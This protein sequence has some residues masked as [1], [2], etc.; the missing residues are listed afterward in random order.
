VCRSRPPPRPDSAPRPSH[1]YGSRSASSRCGRAERDSVRKSS[2]SHE[3]SSGSC[4]PWSRAHSVGCL[5]AEDVAGSLLAA[6]TR[7]PAA[8]R[9]PPPATRCSSGRAV[10]RGPPP[11]PG[12]RRCRSSSRNGHEQQ[13]VGDIPP[14]TQGV[15]EHAADRARPTRAG[16][17]WIRPEPRPSVLRA[18][19]RRSATSRPTSPTTH[20]SQRYPYLD[21]VRDVARH[22]HEDPAADGRRPRVD[23]VGA[24]RAA[25]RRA[26]GAS[27]RARARARVA[28][29]RRVG[30]ERLPSARRGSN[31]KM[32]A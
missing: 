2:S 28:R 27:G 13:L 11:R 23:P 5:N 9:V 21:A 25:D 12:T 24:R 16:A 8:D 4:F 3:R 32:P 30:L 1:T 10:H 7:R 26:R 17:S 14:A 15:N 22:D 31:P 20:S 19:P 29:A 6:P 18:A